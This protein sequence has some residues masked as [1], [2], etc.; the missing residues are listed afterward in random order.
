MMKLG[1]D[2]KPQVMEATPLGK[3]RVYVVAPRVFEEPGDA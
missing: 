1:G 3:R 2:G